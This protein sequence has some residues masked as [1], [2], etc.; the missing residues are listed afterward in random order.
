VL[1]VAVRMSTV[2]RQFATLPADSE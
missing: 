2:W 1:I